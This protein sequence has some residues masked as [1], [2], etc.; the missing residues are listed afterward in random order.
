MKAPTRVRT[1]RLLLRRPAHADAELIYRRY[2][3]DPAVGR[4]L[5]W[6]IH[7]SVG[8]TR[9]FLEFS[10]SEWNDWPAG[11]YLVFTADEGTLLGSTG[12]AFE[13]PAVA[14]TG[15]VIAADSWGEGIA[16]EAVGAMIRLAADLGVERL[17][18]LCHVDHKPSQRVL[19]KAGFALEVRRDRH[20]EFPNLDPGVLHDVF[21]YALDPLS[22]QSR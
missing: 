1:N 18:A 6:P 2:A 9:V 21:V 17:H 22:A 11:P 14:S 16:T 10:D 3:G 12:L 7:E 15:Y 8:D 5:A 4:Y 19:E 20:F 13:S